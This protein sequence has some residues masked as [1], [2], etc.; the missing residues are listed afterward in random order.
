MWRG[1]WC[2]IPQNRREKCSN[3]GLTG[4]NMIVGRFV[5]VQSVPEPSV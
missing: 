3:Y 2:F 4:S 1:L 5:P